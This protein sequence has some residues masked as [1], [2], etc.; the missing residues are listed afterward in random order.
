MI[1]DFC[2]T[3]WRVLLLTALAKLC[4]ILHNPS[5]AVVVRTALSC[6]AKALPLRLCCS[7][8]GN[9]NNASSCPSPAIGIPLG[10]MRRF[11]G[12]SNGGRG[13]AVRFLKVPKIALKQRAVCPSL[14]A[15]ELANALDVRCDGGWHGQGVGF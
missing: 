5:A 2:D 10:A 11:L 13:G 14:D 15:G 9:Q 3:T 4:I 8:V 6:L 12:S 7:T 1:S